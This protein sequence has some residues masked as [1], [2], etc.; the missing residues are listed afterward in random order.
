MN[1]FKSGIKY[2][3]Q[4]II[5]R[6]MILGVLFFGVLGVALEIKYLVTEDDAVA[7]L[8]LLCLIIFISLAH[9]V[10]HDDMKDELAELR[11]QDASEGATE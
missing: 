2:V 6:P 9:S 1:K 11:A 3:V 4:R 8:V 7:H 10:H 5:E